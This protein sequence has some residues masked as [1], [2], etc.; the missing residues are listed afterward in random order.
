MVLEFFVKNLNIQRPLQKVQRQLA[1]RVI[2]GYR[3]ISYEV[4][5]LIART[6]WV[7]VAGKHYSKIKKLKEDGIWSEEGEEEIKKEEEMA[8][9][10]AWKS[11]VKKEDLPGPKL[12]AA[13]VI[14]FEAW[15]ERTQ[16]GTNYY[17]TQLLTG[18]GCFNAYLQRIKKESAMCGYCERFVDNTEH[19]LTECEEWNIERD[20]LNIAL[21][22]PIDLDR[23]T[24]A[25]G[26]HEDKGK[27]INTFARRVMGKK[28][29]RKTNS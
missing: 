19:T 23:I 7:L 10:K 16:G 25:L 20:A 22:G 24:I 13:I 3:T 6:P 27:A 14:N 28:K 5:T 8:M 1:V 4:A 12:R 18:H 2:T 17:L 26:S 11:R 15:M 9:F 21:D 29:K